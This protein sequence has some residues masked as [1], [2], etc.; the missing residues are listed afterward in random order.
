MRMCCL[1][2]RIHNQTRE[3][4]RMYTKLEKPEKVEEGQDFILVRIGGGFANRLKMAA[5]LVLI[6]AKSLTPWRDGILAQ[7]IVK[8]DSIMEG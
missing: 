3:E 2:L 7:V 1:S 4:N 6:A 8:T 5:M